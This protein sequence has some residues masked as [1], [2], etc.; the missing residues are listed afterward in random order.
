MNEDALERR[1]DIALR[2]LG[3]TRDEVGP[4]GVEVLRRRLT[5]SEGRAVL[6]LLRADGP[7]RKA[8]R[9]R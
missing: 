4:E 5:G 6:D 2:E 1:V 3:M 7:R 9:D 8:D